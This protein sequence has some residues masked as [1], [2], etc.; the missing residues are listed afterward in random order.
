MQYY[1][2]HDYWR[3]YIGYDAKLPLLAIDIAFTGHCTLVAMH[4]YN[5]K[6]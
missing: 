2:G 5:H 3:G 4:I 6:R 1:Y